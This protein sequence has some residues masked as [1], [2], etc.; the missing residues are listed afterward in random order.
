[1]EDCNF[2]LLDKLFGTLG[3]LRQLCPMV[4]PPKM[5]SSCLVGFVKS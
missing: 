4:Y 3:R 2:E 5:N 1:M